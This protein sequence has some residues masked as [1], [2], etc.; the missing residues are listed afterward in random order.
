MPQDRVAQFA[1]MDAQKLLRETER[2]AGS[3]LIEQHDELIVFNNELENLASVRIMSH[4][5]N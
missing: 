2:A 4:D 5:R 1:H 3:E